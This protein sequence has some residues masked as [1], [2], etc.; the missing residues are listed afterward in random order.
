M[1]KTSPEKLAYIREWRLRNPDKVKQYH[2]RHDPKKLAYMRE[3]SKRESTR[4]RGR[5]RNLLSLY[6]ITSADFDA[7]AAAQGG[8]CAICDE[9]PTYGVGRRLHVDHC[10]TTGKIRQLLC[11]YCNVAIGSL[12]DRID[13]LQRA[14][15]YLTRHR[16]GDA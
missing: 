16:S 13:I 1:P 10:H 9:V 2:K 7:M 5:N 6:G 14:I 15:D 8:R 11:S 12:R 3:Y 4:A